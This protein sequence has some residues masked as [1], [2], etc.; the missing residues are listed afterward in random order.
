MR[1]VCSRHEQECRQKIVCATC[2]LDFRSRNALYQ[3]SKRK[4]HPLP[5]RTKQKSTKLRASTATPA[6]NVVFVPVPTSLKLVLPVPRRGQVVCSST[7]TDIESPITP[8]GPLDPQQGVVELQS[9]SS[10]TTPSLLSPSFFNHALLLNTPSDI[11]TPDTQIP[12]LSSSPVVSMQPHSTQLC[13]FGTQT[14]LD[15]NSTRL[16]LSQPTTVN[17]CY[18]TPP[19]DLVEFGTQ[20]PTYSAHYGICESDTV[21]FGTQTIRMSDLEIDDSLFCRNLL[22]PECL[23]FGTQ[24]LDYTYDCSSHTCPHGTSDTRDQS[25]QTQ[26]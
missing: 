7:Q 25:S 13:D 22:P 4:G 18:N 20:T 11:V 9:S 14:Q 2:G 12:H 8:G 17:S 10:Q 6:V 1:D 24:T 19:L 26:T 16:A 15:T 21:D 3:H 23:D 5:S